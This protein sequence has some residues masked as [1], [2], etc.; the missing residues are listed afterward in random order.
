MSSPNRTCPADQGGCGVFRK[1]RQWYSAY[2]TLCIPC[3][4]AANAERLAAE[5]RTYRIAKLVEKIELQAERTRRAHRAW[6]ARQ[7]QA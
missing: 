6:V 3:T 2:T 1:S 5:L 7:K 4:L